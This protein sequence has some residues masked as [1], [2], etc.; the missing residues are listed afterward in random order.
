MTSLIDRRLRSCDERERDAVEFQNRASVW[1][2][3]VLSGFASPRQRLRLCEQSTVNRVVKHQESEINGTKSF[4]CFFFIQSSCIERWKDALNEAAN[5]SGS[6]SR[7]IKPESVLIE[8]IVEDVLKRLNDLS[9]SDDTSDL[10]T[11]SNLICVTT[12]LNNYGMVP[13]N[14]S[15]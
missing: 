1:K 3:R 11:F 13:S 6:D 15:I 10:R 9:S 2:I 4:F 14:L 7:V 8:A 5:L 12:K